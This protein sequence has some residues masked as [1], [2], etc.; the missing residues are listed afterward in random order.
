M[1]SIQRVRHWAISVFLVI[2]VA[3]LVSCTP[4]HPQSTFDAVGDVA[5]R[6]LNLF[7]WIFWAA[8]IVFVV[9]EGALIYT[10][11]R[12]RRR[13]GDGIPKQTHGNT[14]IEIAWTLAPAIVLAI[15]AVPTVTTLIDL[16]GAP[17]DNALHVRAIGHQWWFEFEYPEQGVTTA[18]E[19]HVPVGRPVSVTLE[20]KDVIHSFWIPKV[21]GKVDMVPNHVNRLPT[22]VIPEDK[23]GMYLGQCA[24][25]CGTAHALMKFRVIAETNEEFDNWV[26][27]QNEPGRAP[28]TELQQKGYDLFVGKGSCLACHTVEGTIAQSKTGPS[29]THF[30]SRTSLGAGLVENTPDNLALW[31]D[32]P[33]NLKPGTIMASNAIIYRDPSQGLTDSEIESLV[34]Y[35]KGLK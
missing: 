30:G 4:D 21:V 1:T 11:V 5:K 23:P 25:L 19:L 16:S 33:D 31:L 28:S 27:L 20:S 10:V 17:P 13:P 18:N 3:G 6:Q 9:V 14:K 26:R 8:V 7:M 35:L 34:A 24:E 12:Y 22:F 2:L 15:V 32:N 29:L